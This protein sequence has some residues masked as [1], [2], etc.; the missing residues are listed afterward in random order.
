MRSKS[1]I[2][3]G[4]SLTTVTRAIRCPSDDYCRG[5]RAMAAG[6]RAVFDFLLSGTID[7]LWFQAYSG[8]TTP[9]PNTGNN[10]RWVWW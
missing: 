9:D 1:S 3:A 5:T 6:E 7:N 4:P 10:T 2:E 8:Y